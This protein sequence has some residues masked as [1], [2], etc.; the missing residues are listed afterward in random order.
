MQTIFSNPYEGNCCILIQILLFVRKGLIHDKSALIQIPIILAANRRKAIIWPIAGTAYR[1]IYASLYLDVLTHGGRVTHICVGNITIIGSDNG[2]SPG[3][4]QAIIWTNAG[5]LL[6]GPLETNFREILIEIHTFSFKK[7]H[8]NMSSGKWQPFCFGRNV[9]ILKMSRYF[10]GSGQRRR[11]PNL[12]HPKDIWKE[13][14]PALQP[15][16][17]LLFAGCRHED[18]CDN[19]IPSCVCY[20]WSFWYYGPLHKFI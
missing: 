14:I 11:D 2:L 19:C 5:I 3:R 15:K 6:I 16:Q 7:M 8:L 10:A 4:R 20:K 9:L 12:S 17:C 13:T 1:Q 18:L